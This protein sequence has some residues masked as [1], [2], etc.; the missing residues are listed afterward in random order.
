VRASY[1][2]NNLLTDVNQT[3][4]LAGLASVMH[5]AARPIGKEIS[6]DDKPNE[7]K[8]WY[9]SLAA[10]DKPIYY[11]QSMYSPFLIWLNLAEIEFPAHAAQEN[12]GF[13]L[14]LNDSGISEEEGVALS[15]NVI[16]ELRLE[17]TFEFLPASS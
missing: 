11:F 6:S 2:S 14:T 8:T 7:S 4:A 5:N 3:E 13:H 1:Y 17:Q 9:T 16:S 10:Q 12:L 15:G